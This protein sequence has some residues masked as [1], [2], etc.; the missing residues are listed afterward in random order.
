LCS[1]LKEFS[2]GRS[3]S[4]SYSSS[5]SSSCTCT[6]LL[7]ILKNIQGELIEISTMRIRKPV[8]VQDED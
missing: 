8:Q 4:C 2:P 7:V 1:E 6:G 3:H 5:F